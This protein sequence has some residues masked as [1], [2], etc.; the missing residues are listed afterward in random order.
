[1]TTLQ[2]LVLSIVQG[3]TEFLPI[4]SSAHLILIPQVTGWP[5]QGLAFDVAAHLGSLTAVCLY[6]RR[7]LVALSQAW[8]AWRP[9]RAPTIDARLAWGILFGTVPVGL[10]GLMAHDYIA[11]E[12]RSPLLIAATTIGF[13]FA[14]WL[15]DARGARERALA[16]LNWRDV[17][18]I[19]CAQALAL[20][21]GVSRSG[22]TMTAALALGLS[23]EA[24]ARFS[25][26][27]S[28]PVIVLA[29]GLEV[30]ALYRFGGPQPWVALAGVALGAGVSALA[31]I[32]FFLSFIERIG[33]MPFVLYRLALGMLLIAFFL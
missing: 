11:A 4:S 22:A 28:I 6:F 27:L 10:A 7:D 29:S 13:G 24:G 21:P 20:I 23:R 26:L 5:D 2:L 1:M 12:L 14:L 32:H 3:I 18:V 15:A 31:C 25:F 16:S 8:L 33:M 19:G 9:G 17:V 30:I